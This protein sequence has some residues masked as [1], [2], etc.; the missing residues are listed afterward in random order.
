MEIPPSTSDLKTIRINRLHFEQ[1]ARK[2]MHDQSPHYSFIDLSRAGIGL[3]VIVTE[4]DISSPEEAAEFVKKLRNL[5][6]Y[7]GSC[8]GDMKEGSTR[9]DAN[10][11]VRRSGEPLG[12]RCEIKNNISIRNI[13]K[14]I[15]FE[16]KRHVDVLES[17]EE[18][19]K[20]NW[21]HLSAK[22]T[23]VN[24]SHRG[25]CIALTFSVWGCWW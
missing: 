2:F 5:L 9:C 16:A 18:I 25:G 12:T 8:D 20:K 7:I 1:D 24:A 21:A 19:I 22:G 10:I 6:R 23:R 11:S 15:E 14:A 3:T 13:I 17:G 4:P